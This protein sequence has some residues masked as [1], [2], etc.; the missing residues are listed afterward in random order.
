MMPAVLFGALFVFSLFLLLYFLD[1]L[2]FYQREMG[3]FQKSKFDPEYLNCLRSRQKRVKRKY[4]KNLLLYLICQALVAQG[5]EKK[6]RE[7]FPFLRD[8]PLY[9]IKVDRQ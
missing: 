9:G 4:R 5:E 7:L 6:A 3:A 2:K 8:D 1:R